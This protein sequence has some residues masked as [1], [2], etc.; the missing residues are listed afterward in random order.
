MNRRDDLLSA[1][2]RP[3]VGGGII[4]VLK[5]G[6]HDKGILLFPSLKALAIQYRGGEMRMVC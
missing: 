5:S 6:I 2:G 3:D 1:R 4:D